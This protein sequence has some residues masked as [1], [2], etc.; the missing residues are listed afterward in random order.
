VRD[1]KTATVSWTLK[2]P[3]AG[4]LRHRG[5][6]APRARPWWSGSTAR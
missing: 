3:G 5:V 6:H 2:T 4:R 1:G